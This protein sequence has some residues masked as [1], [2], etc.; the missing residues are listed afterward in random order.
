[1]VCLARHLATFVLLTGL[2]EVRTQTEE[3]MPEIAGV[4]HDNAG[5]EGEEVAAEDADDQQVDDRP[6]RTWTPPPKLKYPHP[7][8]IPE[9]YDHFMNMVN[10]ERNGGKFVFAKFY[11]PSPYDD[12]FHH[13]QRLSH[14]YRDSPD[15]DILSIDCQEAPKICETMGINSIPYLLYWDHDSDVNGTMYEGYHT[16]QD[17]QAFIQEELQAFPR[18]CDFHHKTQCSPK[19]RTYLNQWEHKNL[20]EIEVELRRLDKALKKKLTHDMRHTLQ[21]EVSMCYRLKKHLQGKLREEEL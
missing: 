6:V 14:I 7:M 20:D 2:S 21:W 19:E 12:L 16:V 8:K 13:F 9:S 15:I 18:M 10:L 3:D 1:M 5:G 4:S 17:M 11:I